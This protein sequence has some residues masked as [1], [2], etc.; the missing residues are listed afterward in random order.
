MS[1][2]DKS[3]DIRERVLV[4]NS[5]PFINMGFTLLPPTLSRQD[6]VHRLCNAGSLKRECGF[7]CPWL[8]E[9]D[10]P[11]KREG[12]SSGTCIASWRAP[13]QA[14]EMLQPHTASSGTMVQRKGWSCLAV[15]PG[16]GRESKLAQSTATAP[17]HLQGK[18]GTSGD[19]TSLAAMQLRQEKLGMKYRN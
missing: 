15:A 18:P 3:S 10:V 17:W 14:M 7:C 9:P 19:K 8:P 6:T 1:L 5:H 11:Q 12:M 16:P 4:Y 2:R 13:S